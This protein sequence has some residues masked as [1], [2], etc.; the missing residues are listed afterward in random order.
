MKIVLV[1]GHEPEE[2]GAILQNKK[3]SE[4]SFW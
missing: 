4:Y 2:Q 3:I 1:I